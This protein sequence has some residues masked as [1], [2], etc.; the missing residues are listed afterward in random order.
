[1]KRPVPL[2]TAVAVERDE[3][4]ITTCGQ[5]S[6]ALMALADADARGVTAGSTRG[7]GT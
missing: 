6:R 5:V 4:F 1:V 2:V 7:A 3:R